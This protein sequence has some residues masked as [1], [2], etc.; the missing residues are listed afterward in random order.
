MNDE[1]HSR[2]GK[3]SAALREAGVARPP[4]EGS[5]T[6]PYGFAT[7]VVS[8]FQADERAHATGL[9]LWRRWMLAGA[10]CALLLLGGG[11]L[12]EAPQMPSKPIIPIPSVDHEI[13]ELA[14]R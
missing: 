13:S 8:R 6:A 5:L 12:V 2:W 14:N 1:S 9:A 3:V 7:R 4:A 11:F 10:A